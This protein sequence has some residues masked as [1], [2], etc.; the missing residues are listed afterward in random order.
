[1]NLLAAELRG[2]RGMRPHNYAPS[3][4]PLPQGAREYGYPAA[5]LRGIIRLKNN[6]KGRYKCI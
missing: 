4:C 3:P 5:K 2:I 1:M 6:I